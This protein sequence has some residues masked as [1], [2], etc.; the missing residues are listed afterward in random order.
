MA[1]CVSRLGLFEGKAYIFER[2][3]AYSLEL[4]VLMYA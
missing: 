4:N 1:R 3:H 2:K